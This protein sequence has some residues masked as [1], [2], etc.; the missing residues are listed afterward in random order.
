MLLFGWSYQQGNTKNTETGHQDTERCRVVTK[1][2][3]AQH[4]PLIIQFEALPVGHDPGRFGGAE[5]YKLLF[6]SVQSR[7]KTNAYDEFQRPHDAALVPP[8]R[9]CTDKKHRLLDGYAP[10]GVEPGHFRF[11]AGVQ[12]LYN[13]VIQPDQDHVTQRKP[14]K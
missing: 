14:G 2:R 5:P 9:V 3:D 7:C 1:R 4:T 13:I 8:E 6:Q 10:H 12:H 11:S